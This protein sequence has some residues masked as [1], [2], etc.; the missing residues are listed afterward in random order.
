MK[1]DYPGVPLYIQFKRSDFMIRKNV[2]EIS[3]YS[4]K[5]DLPFFRFWI[6]EQ[7]KSS[8]HDMLLAL[9]DGKSSVFYAAPRFHDGRGL[10]SAW[11]NNSV[12]SESIF[13]R[14]KDIGYLNSGRHH[15][16]FDEN[17][18]W[19]CS[20]PSRVSFRNFKDVV[21]SLTDE[22]YSKDVAFSEELPLHLSNLV[23][24]RDSFDE[25][26]RLESDDLLKIEFVDESRKEESLPVKSS[27]ELTTTSQQLRDL[28]DI[29]LRDFGLQTFIIQRS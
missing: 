12:G 15:V 27:R 14:P 13:V 24:I 8:Q 11:S 23:S 7:S 18:A 1:I 16:S 26:S 25:R 9:D 3:T 19:V 5:I 22:I 4:L 21:D 20:S 6:S 2:R 29:A 17:S 10:N 28:S